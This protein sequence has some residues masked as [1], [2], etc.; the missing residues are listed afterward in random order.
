MKVIERVEAFLQAD[1][2]YRDSDK[3]L[4]L[5]YWYKQGLRLSKEQREIFLEV[6]TTPETI[7]RARRMLMEK[8]PASKEVDD[9]RFNKF[10]QHK[11]ERAISWLND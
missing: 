2:S 3:K 7:T 6:C 8:Y 5:D 11:N 9:E 1:Q 10:Q 4:L